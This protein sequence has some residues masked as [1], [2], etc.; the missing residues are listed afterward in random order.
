[1]RIYREIQNNIYMYSIP[2]YI[3]NK[4]PQCRVLKLY[5]PEGIS[6]FPSE[7]RTNCADLAAEKPLV[8]LASVIPRL[9]KLLY[10]FHLNWVVFQKM[11]LCPTN[12][13]LA[14]S[15]VSPKHFFSS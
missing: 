5:V 10:F 9:H 4:Y 14:A 12:L 6:L 7:I 13:V 8:L 2:V 3:I 15:S 1:M 11:L